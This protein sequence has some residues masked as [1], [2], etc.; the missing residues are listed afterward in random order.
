MVFYF[1]NIQISGYCY[2][3]S[4]HMDRQGNKFAQQNYPNMLKNFLNS[5]CVN[6]KEWPQAKVQ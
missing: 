6:H 5:N 3:K 2:F 4:P 1:W